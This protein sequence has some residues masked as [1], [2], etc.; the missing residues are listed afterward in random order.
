MLRYYVTSC[1]PLVLL[2]RIISSGFPHCSPANESLNSASKANV[3]TTRMAKGKCRDI[4]PRCPR[5][6]NRL[7]RNRNKNPA[8]RPRLNLSVGKRAFSKTNGVKPAMDSDEIEDRMISSLCVIKSEAT[9][10]PRGIAH[11]DASR[12]GLC[13]LSPLPCRRGVA[14]DLIRIF[15]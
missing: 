8:L 7:H 10:E 5:I 11:F 3:N 6:W 9:D 13:Y 14:L 15:P 2:P 1:I 12:R 4:D